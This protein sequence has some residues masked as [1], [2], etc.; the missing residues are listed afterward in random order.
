[1]QT[2]IP[3]SARAT[4]RPLGKAGRVVGFGLTPLALGLFAVGLVMAVPAFF[5]VREIGFML[6]WDGLIALLVVIDAVR[7]P[8]P[9]VFLCD[10]DVCR[11]AAVG[12]GDARGACGADGGRWD[13]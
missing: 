1:M 2:L 13:C 4:A 5:H 8:S 7:L 3:Q 12:A 9:E 11:F 6:G 10:A